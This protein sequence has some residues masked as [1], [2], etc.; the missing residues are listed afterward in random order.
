MFNGKGNFREVYTATCYA[1]MPWVLFQFVKILLSNVLPLSVSGIVTGLGTVML[2]YTFFL[3][4]VAM[5]K[6]HEYDFF[7]FLATGIAII[8]AM[9]LVVFIILMCAILIAQFWT[10]IASIYDEIV[11]R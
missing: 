9:I 2:I 11:H 10:F 8:F 6:V 1:I 3:L 7:K 4:A 5:M